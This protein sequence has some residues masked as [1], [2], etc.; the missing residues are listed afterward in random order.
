MLP[1]CP[2]IM[3][4]SGVKAMQVREGR[5][6][7]FHDTAPCLSASEPPLGRV[8]K[9]GRFQMAPKPLSSVYYLLELREL[10]RH[11][12]D[13]DTMQ[14]P[15]NLAILAPAGSHIFPRPVTCPL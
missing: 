10:G 4:W 1:N 7:R 14:F 6:D 15:P 8:I 11:D 3:A 2:Y 9:L 5:R 13:G 12:T